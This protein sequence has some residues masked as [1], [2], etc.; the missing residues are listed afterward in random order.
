MSF[1]LINKLRMDNVQSARKEQL[2]YG[3]RVQERLKLYPHFPHESL[4][5]LTKLVTG[6]LKLHT[7]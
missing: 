4:L 1:G 7:I 2:T 6:Y 3:T 5:V